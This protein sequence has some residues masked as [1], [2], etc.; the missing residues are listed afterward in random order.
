MYED[1]TLESRTLLYVLISSLLSFRQVNIR[2]LELNIVGILELVLPE[3]NI[4]ESRLL[5]ILLDRNLKHAGQA[6][7]LISLNVHP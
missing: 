1:L 4:E 3:L 6:Q 5:S 2:Y 7:R